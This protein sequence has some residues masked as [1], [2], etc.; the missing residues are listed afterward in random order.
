M[1]WH[2]IWAVILRHMYNFRRNLDR[3]VDAFYWPSLDI[4]VWGLTI[5]AMARMGE[6]TVNQVV[7][8]ISGTILW[9][10]MWRGQSEITV[11]FLE[12]LW[13]E[14]LTN[15]FASP[16][17]LVEWMVG[18]CII[19]LMKLAMT[20]S[21]TSVLAYLLYQSNILDLGFWLVPFTL[22]LILFSWAFGFL[23]TSLFLK[24]GT[25]VQ[26]LAWAGAF[27]LM[28]FS[29]V[30]YPVSVL[31]QWVQAVAAV[32][33]TSYV[34]EGMRSI[35]LTGQMSFDGIIKALLLNAMYLTIALWFFVR[36]FAEAK[37]KGL[38]HLK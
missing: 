24:Y 36:S 19:G 2:R 7:M 32:L 9:F 10:I 37:E 17:R 25:N 15:L 5:S 20:I 13:A 16:L 26:T 27:I 4:V 22:I 6:T 31:P 23:T 8:I 34:F 21:L 38:G 28:P 33:P 14:N 3:L 11:N 18:L 29:A 1:K 12:E 35:I 30:Y